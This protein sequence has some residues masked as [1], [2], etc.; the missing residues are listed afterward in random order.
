ML[1]PFVHETGDGRI[2]VQVTRHGKMWA[3]SIWNRST[4]VTRG[5]F[6]QGFERPQEAFDRGREYVRRIEPGHDCEARGCHFGF[7]FLPEQSGGIGASRYQ[8]AIGL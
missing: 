3:M 2:H 4:P 8:E 6:M 7:E 5:P 1:K